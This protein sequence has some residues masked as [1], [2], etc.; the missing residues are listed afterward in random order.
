MNDLGPSGIIIKSY[1]PFLI[2]QFLYFQDWKLVTQEH[3]CTYTAV[4]LLVLVAMIKVFDVLPAQ[5]PL[6]LDAGTVVESVPQLICAGFVDCTAQ[7][8]GRPLPW[9]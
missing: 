1:Y 8:G 4:T 7:G 6:I 5:S 9:P 2:H 3:S